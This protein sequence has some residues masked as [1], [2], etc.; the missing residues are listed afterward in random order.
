MSLTETPTC[1]SNPLESSELNGGVGDAL[2]ALREVRS[3]GATSKYY[4]EAWSF[5]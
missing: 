1:G 5:D 2:R 4:V 3:A